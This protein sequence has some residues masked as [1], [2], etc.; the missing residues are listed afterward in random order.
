M[1]L[2]QIE[3]VRTPLLDAFEYRFTSQRVATHSD[4]S[5][6]ASPALSFTHFFSKLALAA[7]ASFLSVACCVQ[8]ALASAW[9]FFMKEAL[10]APASFFS[11]AVALHVGPSAKTGP[12]TATKIKKVLSLRMVVRV[13]VMKAS[14][15]PRFAAVKSPCFAGEACRHLPNCPSSFGSPV[16]PVEI[17]RPAPSKVTE[18]TLTSF[19]SAKRQSQT[20]SCFN[21]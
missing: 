20:S 15:D 5:Y 16:I 2:V 14:I 19:P 21:E 13:E 1:R 18:K 7:P 11:A 12:A 6:F 9:H 10:A 3:Q 17:T 4:L 8:A